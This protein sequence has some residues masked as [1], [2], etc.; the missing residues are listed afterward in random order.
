MKTEAFS[1]DQ[2][3]LAAYIR[4][5]DAI[6]AE[7]REASEKLRDLRRDLGSAK[8]RLAQI[9]DHYGPLRG[10]P[11]KDVVRA[12]AAVAEVERE[13]AAA[14]AEA[15]GVQARYDRAARLANQVR[16]FARGQGI[17]VTDSGDLPRS[18]E[19]I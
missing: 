7:K 3:R 2:N 14:V 6:N 4:A 18:V 1:V 12:R 10:D 15:D 16:D 13:V 19:R 11:P 8:V 9:E 17:R 5:A